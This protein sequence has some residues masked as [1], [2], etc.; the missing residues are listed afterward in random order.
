VTP[1]GAVDQCPSPFFS[2]P[3]GLTVRP[4]SHRRPPSGLVES[5]CVRLGLG[6]SI[7]ARHC[8]N[9]DSGTPGMSIC[10]GRAGRRPRWLPGFPG[11]VV[12]PA[13]H[14]SAVSRFRV[15]HRHV[16]QACCS[17]TTH[18]AAPIGTPDQH[19]FDPIRPCHPRFSPVHS[20][21]APCEPDCCPV[22]CHLFSVS[23]VGRSERVINP[24]KF[25]APEPA[26]NAADP[27]F[28]SPDR[29]RAAGRN[30]ALS[31]R[32]STG[33]SAPRPCDACRYSESN[34]YHLSRVR[35]IELHF[36]DLSLNPPPR[37]SLFCPWPAAPGG[38]AA[39]LGR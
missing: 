20:G 4:T 24:S 31:L 39:G 36:F 16:D 27:E 37:C 22:L 7:R 29:P 17:A 1:V 32:Y 19:P 26:S 33:R 6:V 23:V 34:L 15:V 30:R 38:C 13:N 8:P 9:P 28:V 10:E 11:A 18:P 12:H 21:S 35:M 2:R 5:R 25:F 3:R 14:V